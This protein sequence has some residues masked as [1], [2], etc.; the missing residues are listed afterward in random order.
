MTITEK[1]IC[2]VYTG[3]CFCAGDDTW[4]RYAYTERLIGRPV[5]THEFADKELL[6]RLKELSRS[7]FV[8]VCRDEPLGFE[9]KQ[10]DAE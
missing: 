3:I 1:A 10:E 2:D 4:A 9:L 7:D 5:Y 6:D 8:K